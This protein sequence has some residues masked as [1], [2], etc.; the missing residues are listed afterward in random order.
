MGPRNAEK[1]E[2]EG[3][4]PQCPDAAGTAHCHDASNHYKQ[5]HGV[6]ASQICQHR[7]F[8]E[9]PLFTPGPEAVA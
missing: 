6:Q 8:G 3:V 2:Q 5:P 4:L 7:A 9:N 1:V